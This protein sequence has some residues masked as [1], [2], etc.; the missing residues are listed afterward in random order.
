MRVNIKTKDLDLAPESKKY[1]L[2]K[3]LS[4]KKYLGQ[5][6]AL[7]CDVEVGLSAGSHNKGKIYRCEANLLLPGKLL[8]VEKTEKELKKAVEKV[9]DHM[10][11]SIK[12]YKEKMIAKERQSLKE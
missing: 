6:K 9:R 4:L 2:E 12:R 10:Q 5:I 11:R 1:V 3:M 8:R 7:N